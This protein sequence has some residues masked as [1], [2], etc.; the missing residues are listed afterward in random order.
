MDIKYSQN[1][2][3]RGKPPILQLEILHKLSQELLSE[4]ELA[5]SRHQSNIS[6]AITKLSEK[7]LVTEYSKSKRNTKRGHPSRN[8]DPILGAPRKKFGLTDEGIGKFLSMYNDDSTLED[9]WKMAFT[10]F[11]KDNKI[12]SLKFKDIL[13]KFERNNLKFDRD[14]SLTQKF[15]QEFDSPDTILYLLYETDFGDYCDALIQLSFMHPTKNQFLI[16][17][18]NQESNIAKLIELQLIK[19]HKKRY[20]LTILG[21][22]TVFKLINEICDRYV[23]NFSTIQID[24]KR[25]K[26]IRLLEH[27]PFLTLQIHLAEKISEEAEDTVKGIR[28]LQIDDRN[29]DDLINPYPQEYGLGGDTFKKSIFYNFLFTIVF[30]TYNDVFPLIFGKWK[31]L[32]EIWSSKELIDFFI[33]QFSEHP[34]HIYGSM[35]ADVSFQEVFDDYESMTNYNE[36]IMERMYHLG[37]EIQDKITKNMSYTEIQNFEKSCPQVIREL[38]VLRMRLGFPEERKSS[39]NDKKELLSIYE[40]L[41]PKM[42]TFTFY[43]RLLHD[44]KDRGWN[45]S[46]LSPIRFDKDIAK[47]QLKWLKDLKTHRD[48][49]TIKQ[50]ELINEYE[51]IIKNG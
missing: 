32:R 24:N 7:K 51:R 49:V 3:S 14:F 34:N 6:K 13:S 15:R 40:K 31:K 37:L 17:Q 25:E 12:I 41:I 16:N 23:F 47:W 4:T 1:E 19:K 35:L 28:K 46:K 26:I 33:S 42:F 5:S 45:N 29:A 27:S 30:E 36:E 18:Q 38:E 9:F 10:Y 22:L 11:R 43:L 21:I 48:R 20:R 2:K 44:A 50:V 8:D 39:K